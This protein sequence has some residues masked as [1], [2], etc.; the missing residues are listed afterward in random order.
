MLFALFL[1]VTSGTGLT[2]THVG[3]FKDRTSCEAAAK[4]TTI[5][6]KDAATIGFVTIC[7]E[8]PAQ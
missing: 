3:N 7:I 1:I 5:V 6:I 4:S 8:A 2:T